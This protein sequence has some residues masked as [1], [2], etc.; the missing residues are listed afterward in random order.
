M[1]NVQKLSQ[2]KMQNDAGRVI[3]FIEIKKIKLN[4]VRSGVLGSLAKRFI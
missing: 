4:G 3:I 2:N 1:A